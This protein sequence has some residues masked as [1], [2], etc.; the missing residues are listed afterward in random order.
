M[1]TYVGAT[2]STATST[3]CPGEGRATTETPSGEPILSPPTKCN[4]VPS[5]QTDCPSFLIRQILVNL[6]PGATTVPSGMVTSW[7]NLALG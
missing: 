2:I 5:G 6:V 1:N 7:T 3:S 4:S